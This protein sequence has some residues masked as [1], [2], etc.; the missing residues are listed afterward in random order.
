MSPKKE[1]F[2]EWVLDILMTYNCDL[3]SV[4]DIIWSQKYDVDVILT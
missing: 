3:D 2:L 4:L 1:F